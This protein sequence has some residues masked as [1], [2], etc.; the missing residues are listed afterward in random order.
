[1]YKYITMNGDV[2]IKT[3]RL[4][5]RRFVELLVTKCQQL[6]VNTY[7]LLRLGGL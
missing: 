3:D 2:Y 1:M 4:T 6:Y 5:F 7:N